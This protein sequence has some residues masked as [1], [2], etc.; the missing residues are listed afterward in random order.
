[1]GGKEEGGREEAEGAYEGDVEAVMGVEGFEDVIIDAAGGAEEGRVEDERGGLVLQLDWATECVG[2]Y[3]N[4]LV[5]LDADF[6]GE[7]HE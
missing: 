5:Y 7:L 3:E 2:G 4:D 1:M 6:C